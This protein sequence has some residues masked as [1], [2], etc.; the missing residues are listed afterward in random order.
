M[1]QDIGTK[2]IE[3]W[4]QYFHV[5]CPQEIPSVGW[6]ERHQSAQVQKYSTHIWQKFWPKFV[7]V[8]TAFPQDVLH[9]RNPCYG[10]FFIQRNSNVAQFYGTGLQARHKVPDNSATHCLCAAYQTLQ[11]QATSPTCYKHCEASSVNVGT[12]L[13]AYMVPEH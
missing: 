10:M 9:M 13:S 11:E 8:T 1:S 12:H 6:G 2:L 7:Q 5:L 3:S 4:L